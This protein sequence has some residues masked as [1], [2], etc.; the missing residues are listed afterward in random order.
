MPSSLEARTVGD[1]AALAENLQVNE[2]QPVVTL[3]AE[4]SKP[5]LFLFPPGGGE[6]MVWLPLLEH[7]HDRPVYALRVEGLE[8]VGEGTFESLEET[9]E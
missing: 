8:K 6:F 4:G 2:Y 5:P 7:I 1:I 3:P 9:L